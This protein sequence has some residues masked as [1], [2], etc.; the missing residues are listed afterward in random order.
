[1]AGSGIGVV[2]G[3]VGLEVA[4]STDVS[5]TSCR[6]DGAALLSFTIVSCGTSK[7]LPV[8]LGLACSC[9]SID[10]SLFGPPQQFRN[11]NSPPLFFPDCDFGVEAASPDA[12]VD[13]GCN[14]TA[15]L[16][17]VV[18]PG[19]FDFWFDADII[20]ELDCSI[21]VPDSPPTS[22]PLDGPFDAIPFADDNIRSLPV[23]NK[24]LS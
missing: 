1:M 16:L 4:L 8:E 21:P 11:D 18:L 20:A 19:L 7:G 10:S 24:F 22:L 12:D 2:S 17:L 13:G 3:F 14:V 23:C 15:R 9:K 5:L 6:L